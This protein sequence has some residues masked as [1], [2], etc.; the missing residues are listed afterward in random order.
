MKRLTLSYGVESGQRRTLSLPLGRAN[1]MFGLFAVSTVWSAVTVASMVTGALRWGDGRATPSTPAH[2]AS[3]AGGGAVAGAAAGSLADHGSM[4]AAAN[5][6]ALAAVATTAA[7]PVA[8]LHT[9]MAAPPQDVW[10]STKAAATLDDPAGLAA[11]AGASL[12]DLSPPPAQLDLAPAQPLP[13]G[14]V[15]AAAAA[16]SGVGR[17][18][19]PSER[20]GD[21]ST[22]LDGTAPGAPLAAALV[23]FHATRAGQQLAVQFAIENRGRGA[24]AG[25][26]DGEADFH[27]P[28]GR[29]ETVKAT[30]SYKA[31]QLS[32]KRIAFGWPDAEG[33][34]TSVRLVVRDEASG[35]ILKVAYPV[36]AL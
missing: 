33:E 27:H 3:V 9:E 2:A 35:R 6:P 10:T 11:V 19:S 5:E 24:I 30:L 32:P 22:K 7:A 28:D 23:A 16:E 14:R 36:G 31:R 18:L 12:S 1:L 17:L 20:L 29:I 13:A 21:E 34:F 8:P 15:E 25:S 4:V 26:V